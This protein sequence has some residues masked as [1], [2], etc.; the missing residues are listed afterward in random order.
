MFFQSIG[1]KHF[2]PIEDHNVLS[3]FSRE[4]GGDIFLPSLRGTPVYFILGY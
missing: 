4:F 1:G 2:P 3:L